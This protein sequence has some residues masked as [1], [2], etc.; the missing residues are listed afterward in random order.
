MDNAIDWKQI[1]APNFSGSN[2]LLNQGQNTL[3]QSLALI[4]KTAK[5]YGDTVSERNTNDLLM[6]LQQAGT[7][8]EFDATAKT[9]MGELGSLNNNYDAKTLMDYM[10]QRP[11]QLSEQQLRNLQLQQAQNNVLDT[12]MM[13][14]ALQSLV[15]GNYD[16]A[17][18]I[19]PQ[20][21]NTANLTSLT[22][23]V[24]GRKDKKFD[25]DNVLRDDKR[26]DLKLNNET[27]KEANEQILRLAQIQ[28]LKAGGGN[29]GS[30]S[31]SGSGDGSD[32][33]PVL[34][35]TTL[36]PTVSFGDNG[37]DYSG[38]NI[39]TQN[40]VGRESTIKYLLGGGANSPLAGKESSNGKKTYNPV[41]GATGN[42]QFIGSTLEDTVNSNPQLKAMAGNRTGSQLM[43]YL[44]QNP[45]FEQAA[46]EVEMNRKIDSLEKAGIPVNPSTVAGAWQAGQGSFIKIYKAA[47]A[48]PNIP[49]NSVLESV[50]TKVGKMS[51]TA[52]QGY[53]DNMTVGE[54]I[55][56]T[57][58]KIGV[59]NSG[60][61]PA[62]KFSREI[63]VSEINALATEF[64]VELAK[65]NGD[66]R[67]GILK[68]SQQNLE[69]SKALSAWFANPD[70][71]SYGLLGNRRANL[72]SVLK[73]IPEFN[74]LSDT[75]KVKV[76]EIADNT[77][78]AGQTKIPITGL[79]VGDEDKNIIKKQ[80]MLAI[81]KVNQD[82][83][84]LMQND[85]AT[86]TQ[87]Y[88]ERLR[89][90]AAKYGGTDVGNAVKETDVIRLFLG[91]KQFQDGQ[92][93]LAAKKSKRSGKPA[94][95]TVADN[96]TLP[97]TPIQKAIIDGKLVAPNAA[98][99]PTFSQTPTQ[100]TI[101]DSKLLLEK[102]GSNNLR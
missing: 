44:K 87:Y 11:Q 68:D 70:S 49:I 16:D 91:E 82:H 94:V 45:Q 21:R 93:R 51:W 99:N 2:S 50:N 58:K 7:P 71:S 18:K 61:Q 33:L 100:K 47:E 59:N 75:Q 1:S 13:A 8:E 78:L 89:G 32:K 39:P 102:Y 22:E 84:Q 6:R 90:L 38:I 73:E 85:A 35:T 88:T 63:P 15:N 30:G 20:L 101:I 67:K 62:K 14:Q 31:G 81:G 26:E 34:G 55:N 74:K 17:A 19:I 54:F 60:G 64:K 95:P 37:F 66:Y 24:L 57:S 97:Q 69:G 43:D 65:L 98:P 56:Q 76:L 42:F 96:P 36:D 10:Q 79:V 46:A 27:T 23:A 48:N 4:S 29:G 41:S 28:A 9:V 92:A 40:I 86:L 80:V 5:D 83:Q 12:P 3:L 53:P 77:N 25:Q 52:S 72:H